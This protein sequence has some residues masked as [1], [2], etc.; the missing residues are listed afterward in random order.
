M[1]APIWFC[2]YSTIGLISGLLRAEMVGLIVS[3]FFLVMSDAQFPYYPI[4]GFII[5]VCIGHSLKAYHRK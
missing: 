2:I 1:S 3:V 4:L 5:F